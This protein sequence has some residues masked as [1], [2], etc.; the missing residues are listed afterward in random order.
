MLHLC[1]APDGTVPWPALLDEGYEVTGHF[2]GS[3]LHPEEEY[4]LRTEAVNRLSAALG[5]EVV[6]DAYDPEAWLAAVRGTEEE[7]EGGARCGI[8]FRLQLEAAARAAVSR[9][10]AWLCTTLTISPH[11]SPDRI[12]RIGREVAEAAGL[13]W[14]DRIF[15]KGE[16]FR[17][18][19]EAC[20]RMGLYR[21][22]YC[23]CRFSRREESR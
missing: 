14:V 11:K 7:P 13:A 6:R 12:N 15:R 23:G 1:C 4:R 3:N 10:C 20:R 2:Y 19:V 5:R 17:R 18:S 16:G 21:Q 8:C 9:D 22:N